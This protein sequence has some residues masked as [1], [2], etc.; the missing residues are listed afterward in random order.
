MILTTAN[1]SASFNSMLASS[2]SQPSRLPKKLTRCFH[3][4][5]LARHILA[6]VAAVGEIGLPRIVEAV[7]F[8]FV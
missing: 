3:A 5:F 2:L 1:T 8:G 7:G 6:V 4:F